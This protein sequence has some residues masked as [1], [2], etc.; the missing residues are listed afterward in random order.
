MKTPSFWY[1]PRGTLSTLLSPLGWAYGKGG[2][3]LRTFKKTESFPIPIISVGNIVAGGSGKTPV[4]L[5][6]ARLFQEKG[7]TVHFV[8]RGY[9]GS[10]RGPL[11]VNTADHS[12]LEVGDEPLL[13]A[14]QAPTWVA[15]ER[16]LGVHQALKAGAQ[17]I[18]L[19]DGHQTTGLQKDV[20]FVVVDPQQRFGNGC[21]IPAG[22]LRE[23]LKE[24]LSRADALIGMGEGNLPI[25]KPLFKAQ[26]IPHISQL[27]QT[28]VIAFCGLGYPQ[29]FYD[30]LKRLGVSL[31]TTETFP[32]HYMYKEEDLIRLNNLAK[33]HKATLMTTRKDFIKIPL[34]CQKNIHVLDIT[35]QFEDSEGI[36]QYILQKIPSLREDA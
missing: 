28:P 9:G 7:I 20:S 16:A 15:K 13:L 36:Y 8:T 6:L 35:I 1:Q 32:D 25:S 14:E 29:K 2:K 10:I 4:A 31:I 24:G 21:I 12:P 5:A 11:Q 27:P 33:K 17:L 23:D 3:V 26:V 22:P 18:I 34:T 19:D 30:T